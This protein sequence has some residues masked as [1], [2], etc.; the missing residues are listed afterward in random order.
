MHPGAAPGLL[1]WTFH[2]PLQEYFKSL[3]GHGLAVTALEEWVSH[4]ASKPGSASR[5]ENRA[6]GEIPMFLSL[7][8][9]KM[10]K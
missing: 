3:G 5:M 4:R 9:G 10:L 2:R 6:R 7:L 8:A 1:T